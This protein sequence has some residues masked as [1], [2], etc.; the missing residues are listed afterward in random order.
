MDTLAVT[1]ITNF[2][3][4]SE[5]FFLAGLTI[6]TPKAPF[7]A[8][9]FWGGAMFALASSAMIGGIDH[10]FVEA[11][12]LPRTLIQR[13]NWIVFGLATFCMLL[14][15]ARQFLGPRWQRPVLMVGVIQ[16]A[17]YSVAVLA[18]GDFKVVILDYLPAMVLLLALSLRGLRQG[19]GSWPMIV[20]ILVLLVASGAQAFGV[21]PPGVLDENGLYHVVAMVGFVFMYRGGQRLKTA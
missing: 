2:I 13:S 7:S 3:L 12:G 17:V 18:V 4:A 1:S 15:T 20:G 14:A 8:A 11:A 10:G 6:A 19:T 5:L 21:D 16:L 9:W